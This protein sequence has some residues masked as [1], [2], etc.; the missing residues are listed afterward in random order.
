MERSFYVN[1]TY[2]FICDSHL[3]IT[4]DGDESWCQVLNYLH[5]GHTRLRIS[6]LSGEIEEELTH[7][8]YLFFIWA[9]AWPSETY[10]AHLL[11][12]AED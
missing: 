3:N 11:G 10:R 4:S 8:V 9:R 12:S 1:E 2:L 5:P 6:N 7:S